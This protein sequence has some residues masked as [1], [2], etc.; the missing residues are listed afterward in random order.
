MVDTSEFE[1]VKTRLAALENRHKI[2]KND[3]NRPTLRR[4]TTPGG[5]NGNGNDNGNGDERPTL[6]RRDS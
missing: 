1:D 3:E 2:Q 6:K 5:N 4:A